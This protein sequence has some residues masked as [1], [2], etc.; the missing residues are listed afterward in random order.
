MSD[1]KANTL[2]VA[3]SDKAYKEYSNIAGQVNRNAC[4]AAIALIWALKSEAFTSKE[5]TVAI[6][7]FS[8][9]FFDVLTYIV[10]SYIWFFYHRSVERKY[11]KSALFS[12]PAY[13][14][15]PYNILSFFRFIFSFIGS[16][17]LLQ[18]LWAK[19]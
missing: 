1:K 11:T 4:Y 9:I 17:F 15:W 2:T 3:D 16:I 14:N 8:S 6:L 5:F 7:F 18:I 13:I 10:P 12:A 19:F